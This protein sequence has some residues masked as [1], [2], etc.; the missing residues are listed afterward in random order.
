MI[1]SSPASQIKTTEA[2]IA[3]GGELISQTRQNLLQQIL[4]ACS[5]TT[6]PT[7]PTPP[8]TPTGFTATA[9]ESSILLSWDPQPSADTFE[10]LYST[11]NVFG[12]AVS[13]AAGITGTSFTH[14]S[15]ESIQ[16]GEKYYY[17]LRAVN[18]DGESDYAGSVTARSFVTVNSGGG[19]RSLT[20]PSGTWTMGTIIFSVAAKPTGLQITANSTVYAW[21]GAFWLDTNTFVPSNGVAISGAFT[22][23]NNTGSNYTFW[24]T[25]P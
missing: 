6:A 2:L 18:G 9:Q 3:I 16:V 17:W 1:V 7:P 23:I 4:V 25:E 12:V 21:T 15:G 5:I 19:T 24:D 14:D 22:I 8:S 13:L 20:T 10:I 11:S